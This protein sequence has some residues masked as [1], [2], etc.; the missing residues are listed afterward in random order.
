MSRTI[1][2]IRYVRDAHVG[3]DGGALHLDDDLGALPLP[4]AP[5]RWSARAGAVGAGLGPDLSIER[6]GCMAAR[7]ECVRPWEIGWAR[8]KVSGFSG[9]SGFWSAIDQ[10]DRSI[11]DR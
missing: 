11:V 1:R 8:L 3:A 5:A 6:A 2:T 9:F 7:P 10:I 4:P